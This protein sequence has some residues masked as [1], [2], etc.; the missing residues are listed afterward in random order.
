MGDMPCELSE[1]RLS[2]EQDLLNSNVGVE[3]SFAGRVAV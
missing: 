1:L 2:A 3:S